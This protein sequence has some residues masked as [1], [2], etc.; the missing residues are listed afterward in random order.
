MTAFP[1]KFKG[2]ALMCK[3][4]PHTRRGHMVRGHFRAGIWVPEHFRSGTDVN[5]HC[6]IR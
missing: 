2:E 6:L 1:N 3:L 5:A 4:S